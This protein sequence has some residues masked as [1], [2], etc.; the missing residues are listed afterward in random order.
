ML[1]SLDHPNIVKVVKSY[2]VDESYN[3]LEEWM[4][5]SSVAEIVNPKA[6]SEHQVRRLMVPLFDAV[7][8]CHN[9]GVSH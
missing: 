2:D 6:Y 7:A 5:G 9:F 1:M 3:F 4:R 8:Y